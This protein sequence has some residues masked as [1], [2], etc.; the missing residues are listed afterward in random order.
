VRS[1]SRFLVV[2]LALTLALSGL[3]AF[4]AQQ[5]TRSHQVTADRALR[6]YAT[7]AAWEFVSASE[8]Q[9]DRSL[10]AALGPVV[11]TPAVSPYDSLAPA[12]ALAASADSVLRC[13]SEDPAGRYFVLDYR[14]GALSSSRPDR[15]KSPRTW[16]RDSLLAGPRRS[17]SGGTGYGLVWP[18]GGRA[19]EIALYG[20][21]SLRYSGYAIH[22]APLAAYGFVTCS[23]ALASVFHDVLARHPLLPR[24]VTGG[25]TNADLAMVEVTD[26]GGRQVFRAGRSAGDGAFEGLAS[27]GS[28]LVRVRLP[29]AVAGRL[30]VARPASRLPVLLGL[31]ALTAGLAI[32]AAR[33]LRREQDLVRLRADFTSSVSHE[34]RTPL[35]QI[36]LFAETLELGRA[37]SEDARREAIDIIVQE[38]RRLAHLVENVL[39]FS[40]AERQMIEVRKEML[41][42]AP[43]VREITERFVP[44]AGN[45]ALRIRTEL[46]E[47]LIAPVDSECLHQILINLLDN[48]VKYGGGTV[49]VRTSLHDQHALI[50]VEDGG[51]GIPAADRE[52]IWKPFI[53]LRRSDGVPGSGIGLAVVRQLVAAHGGRTG[54][55]DVPTGGTRFVVELPGALAVDI[56]APG[57]AGRVV[58]ASWPES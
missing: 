6:D 13:G 27:S 56:A 57:D 25:V 24:S 34:L 54:I 49:M 41:A 21:K 26:P 53:R 58:E 3:L 38:A 20:I 1:S 14:T 15:D 36:L 22:D 11:G 39:Q 46:D 43:L 33:Q 18:N 4:E 51:P 23:A 44:L 55:E 45:A 35:T 32:V 52:R 42:M 8:E 29:A 12:S 31:L 7:V 10:A 28:L 2:L 16:L 17:L 9:L 5:A 30:V 40:R 50:E 37:G 48:A 19:D 47:R